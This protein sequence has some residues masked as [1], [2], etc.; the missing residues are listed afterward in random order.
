MTGRILG[1]MRSSVTAAA[2]LSLCLTACGSSCPRPEDA[3]SARAGGHAET[4]ASSEDESAAGGGEHAEDHAAKAA[5]PAP[6]EARADPEESTPPKKEEKASVPEPSFPEDASV[7]QAM[8]AIP[9]GTERANIDPEELGAP[10]HEP[11]LF[12]PCNSGAMKFKVKVAVWG[13][14][15]VGVDVSTPNK[16]L[17]DCVKKQVRTVEWRDKVRSLNTIEFQL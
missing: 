15:A 8:A 17:A 9:R 1:E 6:E 11:E 2:L 16:K 14:H 12:A 10:L 7:A 3:T 4:A 5:K 13:G